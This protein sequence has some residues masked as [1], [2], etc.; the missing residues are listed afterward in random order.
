MLRSLRVKVTV[1]TSALP[2]LTYIAAT[3]GVSAFRKKKLGGVEKNRRLQNLQR[4]FFSFL[5]NEQAAA[6]N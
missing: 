5:A 3:L 6:Q 2:T 4:V 1:Q